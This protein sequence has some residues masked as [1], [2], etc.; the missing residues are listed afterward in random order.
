MKIIE[1]LAYLIFFASLFEKIFHA[2]I[3]PFPALVMAF[4]ILVLLV[5]DI[6]RSG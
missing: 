6:I 5:V 3:V 4:G 2:R 1:P